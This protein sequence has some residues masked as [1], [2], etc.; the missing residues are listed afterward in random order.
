MIDTLGFIFAIPV[1]VWAVGGVASMLGIGW[2]AK[3][4][5]EDAGDAAEKIGNAATKLTLIGLLGY[6]AYTKFIKKK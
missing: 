1:A 6:F 5:A 2:L 4:T 3:E